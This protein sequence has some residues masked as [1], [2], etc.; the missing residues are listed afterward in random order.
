MMDRYIG[1]VL[2]GAVGKHLQMCSFKALQAW[3]FLEEDE[4][5]EADRAGCLW[6]QDSKEGLAA[7]SFSA[8]TVSKQFRNM[9]LFQGCNCNQP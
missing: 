8:A 7:F 9:L 4:Q 3:A 1:S 6:P 5:A 2:L